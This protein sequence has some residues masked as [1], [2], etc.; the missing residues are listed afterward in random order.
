MEE[1]TPTSDATPQLRCTNLNCRHNLPA[2]APAPAATSNKR[3]VCLCGSS[4]TVWLP[5][6]QPSHQVPIF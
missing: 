2:A 3:A 5:E 1:S 4:M 6:P